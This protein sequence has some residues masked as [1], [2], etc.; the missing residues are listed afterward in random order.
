ME[1]V[2]C[3]YLRALLG[4]LA[5]EREQDCLAISVGCGMILSLGLNSLL[6][7]VTMQLIYY[8]SLIICFKQL[9]AS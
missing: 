9:M 5:Y 6:T 8:K 4:V 7:R 1:K 3:L 2:Q